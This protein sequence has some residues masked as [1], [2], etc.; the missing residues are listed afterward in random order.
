M[1]Y[2]YVV[3]N[4]VLNVENNLTNLVAVL[5]LNL[6]QKLQKDKVLMKHG[7]KKILRSVQLV[8]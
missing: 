2:A 8:N 4:F 6:G 3:R 1:L 5:K 7:L